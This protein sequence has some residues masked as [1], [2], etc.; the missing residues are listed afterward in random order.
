MTL[1]YGEYKM[2]T[3][4]AEVY[5]TPVSS[6]VTYVLKTPYSQV[7]DFGT[8]YT[9]YRKEIFTEENVDAQIVSTTQRYKSELA[10]LQ[11]KKDAI[12]AVK[13]T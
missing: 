5:Q 1:N 9:L 8:A 3:I 2:E 4:T 11:A 12:L 6:P 13:N 7:D 10:L